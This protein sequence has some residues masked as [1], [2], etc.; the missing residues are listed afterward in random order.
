MQVHMILFVLNIRNKMKDHEYALFK[1][2]NY[3]YVTLLTFKNT[4]FL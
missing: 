2:I 3:S 1:N 4:I